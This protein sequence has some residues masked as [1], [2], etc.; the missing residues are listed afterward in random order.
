MPNEVRITIGGDAKGVLAEFDRVRE[1]SKKLADDIKERTR[2]IAIAFTAVGGAITGVAAL[3]IKSS[4]EQQVGINRLDQALKNVGQS[5]M[6]QKT[7]IE[8]VISAQQTKTNFSDEQQ[9]DALQKLVTVGGQWEGSLAALKITTDV[10]AGANIDLNA[11]ALLVGKAIAGETGSLSRYGISL[12]EG[13]TQTEIMAALT[14]QFGGAAEAAVNPMTQLKNSMDDMLQVMGNA[15]LPIVSKAAAF[16]A[17]IARKITAWSEA[18]PQLAKWLAIITAAVGGIMVVVGGFL[19][20][21][22]ALITGIGTLGMVIAVATGPIGLITL[23]IAA[24]VAGGVLL[25]VKWNSIWPQIKSAIEP[26]MPV[27][28]ALRIAVD[29]LA[30]NWA[31]AWERVKGLTKGAAD[32][33]IGQIN[34]IGDALASFIGSLSRGDFASAWDQFWG[35]LREVVGLST[36]DIRQNIQS[37]KSFIADL[38]DS[39]K[40]VAS[41]IDAIPGG[42]DIAPGLQE[43]IDSLRESNNALASDAENTTARISKTWRQLG[44]SLTVEIKQVTDELGTRW[45]E[46]GEV[47]DGTAGVAENFGTRIR[48]MT[49]NAS[50][51]VATMAEQQ[52]AALLAMTDDW[53]SAADT[54]T[55]IQVTRANDRFMAQSQRDDELAAHTARV[56]A[57][58]Q[59]ALDASMQTMN[60]IWLDASNVLTANET[61]VWNQ[62]FRDRSRRYTEAEQLLEAHNRRVLSLET[63]RLSRMVEDNK[64]AARQ[65]IDANERTNKSIENGWDR[66]KAATD[67]LLLKLRDLGIGATEILQGW[68]SNARVSTSAIAD[69]LKGVGE[70]AD[71]L[72]RIWKIALEAAGGNFDEFVLKIKAAT[73]SVNESVGQ[74]SNQLAGQNNLNNRLVNLGPGRFAP[75]GG[76]IPEDPSGLWPSSFDTPEARA[77]V[78]RKGGIGLTA[79]GRVILPGDQQHMNLLESQFRRIGLDGEALRI[80]VQQAAVQAQI[81]ARETR[82]SFAH[83]GI[84]PG[85]IGTPRVIMAHGGETVIPPGRNSVGGTV[86]NMALTVNGDINGMD[87]FQQ[88]VTRTIRDAILGGGFANLLARA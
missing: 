29:L 56:Y 62:T 65:Q 8:S 33:I 9:R 86:I 24:L 20:V 13:A 25:A 59:T 3:A 45:V 54:M 28:D 61:E 48:T 81:A 80:A 58:Q 37:I 51:A 40:V 34:G 60:E 78:A 43:A 15:L 2:A 82:G 22:P 17:D 46:V 75:G 10:A 68:A 66:L 42:E 30:G 27:I 57:E 85:P 23:A 55:W 64:T 77:G 6:G 26:V 44:P 87:D 38:L 70:N 79:E 7:A 73:A 67:P 18:H 53:I 76:F 12:K 4:L 35:G 39:I 16:I 1:A 74:M 83:G 32:V 41:V 88:K 52:K 21:L 5:Y 11:A 36:E 47:I 72:K 69:Y 19:L 71:D 63:D 31:S 50:S 49:Q 84:V 14:A